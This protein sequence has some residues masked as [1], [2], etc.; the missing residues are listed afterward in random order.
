MPYRFLQ[1]ILSLWWN[2]VGQ[3]YSPGGRLLLF[4]SEGQRNIF[5]PVGDS[6]HGAGGA[7]LYWVGAAETQSSSK[8]SWPPE[9]FVLCKDGSFC[10]PQSVTLVT[11][12]CC[13]FPAGVGIA[14]PSP[15]RGGELS[16]SLC[17]TATSRTPCPVWLRKKCIGGGMCSCWSKTWTFQP[18]DKKNKGRK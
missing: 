16:C 6:P 14:G 11:H 9:F 8:D 15:P 13:L 17:F 18:E 5:L 3:L 7:W 10:S 2:S 12:S 1:R 4:L